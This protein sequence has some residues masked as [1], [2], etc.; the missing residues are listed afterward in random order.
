MRATCLLLWFVIFCSV[1]QAQTVEKQSGSQDAVK[2]VKDFYVSYATNVM[3]TDDTDNRLLMCKYLTPELIAKVARMRAAIQADPILRAQDFSAELLRTL[4]VKPLEGNWYMV[5]YGNVPGTEQLTKIPLRVTKINGRYLIDYI[6]PDWN[7]SQYGDHL[8]CDKAVPQKVDA[9][10]PLSFM[11]TF[12]AAYVMEFCTMPADLSSRL[13]SL[14]EKYCTPEA[15][16]QFQMADD[17]SKMDGNPEGFDL[18]IDGFDFDCLWI[19]TMAF[20]QL[21]KDSYQ[22]RYT[23]GSDFF[24]TVI[25]KVTQGGNGYQINEIRSL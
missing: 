2:V 19:P 3:K 11:K 17:E 6:T 1:C 18:I 12:Y 5:S 20:T 25:L 10:T 9:S 24:A 23:K 8:L 14:R 15:L 4:Q 13:K 21:D 22:V 16:K 7:G